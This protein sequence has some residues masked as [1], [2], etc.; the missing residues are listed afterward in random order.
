M[1]DYGEFRTL[2]RLAPSDDVPRNGHQMLLF[3]HYISLNVAAHSESSF[4]L[5]VTE[6]EG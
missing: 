4:D 5:L 6:Y 1:S 2:F 3:L